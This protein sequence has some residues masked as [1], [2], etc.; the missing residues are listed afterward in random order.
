MYPTTAPSCILF[1]IIFYSNSSKIMTAHRIISKLGQMETHFSK[2]Y[3]GSVLGCSN[4][5]I[6]TSQAMCFCTRYIGSAQSDTKEGNHLQTN[7]P[8]EMQQQS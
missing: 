5:S 1:G 2:K 7:L 4:F 3:L 8:S 6:K